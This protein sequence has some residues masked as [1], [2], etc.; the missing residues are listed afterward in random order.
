MIS[1]GF[2]GVFAA[3]WWHLFADFQLLFGGFQAEN[4]DVGCVFLWTDLVLF[5]WHFGLFYELIFGHLAFCWCILDRF[6]AE[7]FWV[8]SG[9]GGGLGRWFSDGF[10]G[11]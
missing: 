3:F 9:F 5:G 1:S 7:T 10:F 2:G 8:W 11:D 4:G 6:G